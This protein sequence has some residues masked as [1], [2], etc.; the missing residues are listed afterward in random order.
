[1]EFL[2]PDWLANTTTNLDAIFSASGGLKLKLTILVKNPLFE[3][4]TDVR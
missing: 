1:M 3:S 2:F 4:N